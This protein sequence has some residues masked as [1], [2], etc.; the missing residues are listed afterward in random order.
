MT[1]SHCRHLMRSLEK[2]GMQ[3][4]EQAVKQNMNEWL[5][6]AHMPGGLC[7]TSTFRLS[8]GGTYVYLSSSETT[9]NA[10]IVFA[11]LLVAN[12]LRFITN[13]IVV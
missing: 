6:N 5:L 8:I 7:I 13:L 4:V 2:K 10:R 3:L 11:I 1:L 9:I 12:G